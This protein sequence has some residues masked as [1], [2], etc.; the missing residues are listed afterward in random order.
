M[1]AL[2]TERHCPEVPGNARGTTGNNNDDGMHT[3]ECVGT[4]QLETGHGLDYNALPGL[5]LLQ[6]LVSLSLQ[7]LFQVIRWNLGQSRWNLE[8]D[9]W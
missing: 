5:H 4:G 8:L 7:M 2:V 3:Y 9:R 6:I 1:L